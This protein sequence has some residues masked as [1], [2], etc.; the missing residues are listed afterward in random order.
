MRELK[1][2]FATERLHVQIVVVVIFRIP[3]KGNPRSVGRERGGVCGTRV[4][5]ELSDGPL[6]RWRFPF[7]LSD[8]ENDCNRHGGSEQNQRGREGKSSCRAASVPGFGELKSRTCFKFDFATGYLFQSS[9]NLE[10][11][12]WFDFADEAVAAPRQSLDELR[13]F[14]GITER[15]SNLVYSCRQPVIEIDESDSG[16]ELAADVFAADNAT[17]TS[18]KQYQQLEWLSLKTNLPAF[19]AKLAGMDLYLIPFK[20]DDL[21]VCGRVFVILG[22]CLTWHSVF[23]GWE[24]R[25]C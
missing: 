25:G 10:G 6:L 23:P 16:P 4:G 18:Q 24:R 9:P 2:G 19:L 12:I 20:P 13:L 7:F 1:K 3:A 17:R 11:M 14:G 22:A 21:S 5:R 15:F 8:D